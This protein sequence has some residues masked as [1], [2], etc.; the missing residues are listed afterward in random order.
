[1]LTSQRVLW[2]NVCHKS[3]SDCLTRYES[4]T[5]PN[6]TWNLAARDGKYIMQHLHVDRTV[7]PRN[8]ARLGIGVRG[9]SNQNQEDSQ[10]RSGR[11]ATDCVQHWASARDTN[12]IVA[13]T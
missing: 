9:T 8:S 10:P 1:M 11:C 13:E 5:L 4:N 3:I 12:R 6:D 7:L 2:E